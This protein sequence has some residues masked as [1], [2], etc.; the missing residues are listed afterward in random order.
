VDLTAGAVVAAAIATLIGASIQGSIGFG[1]NLVTV[2]VFALA[3]PEALPATVVLLGLPL[4]AAMVRH[5]HHAIDRGGFAWIVAGRVPGTAA[6]AVV[7]ASV[8][9]DTLKGVIGLS[10]LLAVAASAFA[11]PIRVSPVSQFTGGTVSGVTGTAAGIGG[12]PLALLYQHHPGPTMRA[13]LAASFL[14]GT[15]MSIASLALAREV[16]WT[17][18][19]LAAGLVPVVITGSW[20]G[21]RSHGAL[22]RGW[23]RP[24]VLAFAAVSAVVVLADAVR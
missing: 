5:E 1:M 3:L 13:T 8:S 22:D 12:P 10:V 15:V 17:E 19:G 24:A 18:C 21:R 23:L 7:V 14:V 11:P 9:T 20:I 16:T 6:G 2:P 4:A